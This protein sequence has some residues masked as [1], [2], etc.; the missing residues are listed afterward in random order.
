MGHVRL[1]AGAIALLSGLALVASIG[2]VGDAAGVRHRDVFKRTTVVHIEGAR[3]TKGRGVAR[4]PK[5]SRAISGGWAMT[6]AEETGLLVISS[7]RVGARRWAVRAIQATSDSFFTDLLPTAYCKIGA[8]PTKPV[9]AT[10][11]VPSGETGSVDATCPRGRKAVAGGFEVPTTSDFSRG[12]FPVASRRAG[13]RTWR[14]I[15]YAPTPE[16]AT[17][18]A[19]A[20]CAGPA[21]KLRSRTASKATRELGRRVAVR[22]GKCPRRIGVRAGGFAIKD[23]TAPMFSIP[24]SVSEGRRWEVWARNLGGPQTRLTAIAYCH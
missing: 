13:R 23:R 7:H 1:R 8:R 15:V 18:T 14:L 12:A 6:D 9:S 2:S 10:G 16:G 20:Y 24:I 22:S 21:R 4:C 3:G 11:S 19:Y 5:G 17:V